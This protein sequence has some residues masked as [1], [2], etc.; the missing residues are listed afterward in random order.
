MQTCL[1]SHFFA[2]KSSATTRCKLR[3]VLHPLPFQLALEPIVGEE[4]DD[5]VVG[6]IYKV[7]GQKVFPREQFK[8]QQSCRGGLSAVMLEPRR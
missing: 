7:D 5:V 6:V 2:I 3:S 4:E 1:I 8:Q